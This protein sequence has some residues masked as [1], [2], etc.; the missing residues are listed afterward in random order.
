MLRIITPLLSN[1][2]EIG[3]D[4]ALTMEARGFGATKK[5]KFVRPGKMSASAIVVC[6]GI[7]VLI[8]F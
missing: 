7:A 4:I 5:S 2:I 8:G 1:S 3:T 6:C